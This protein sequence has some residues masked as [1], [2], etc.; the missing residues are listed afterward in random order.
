MVLNPHSISVVIPA[1]NEADNIGLLVS[2]IIEKTENIPLAEII[3][4]DD[5]STDNISA[6][7]EQLKPNASL[8]RL[9]RHSLRSGQSAAL[10]TGIQAARSE[11]IVTMDGDGQNDPVDIQT[12]YKEW[13]AHPKPPM[14]MIAGQRRKRMDTMLKKFTSQAG[15]GIRSFLLKDGVRDTG[16]SLKLFRREDYLRLPYFNHMHRFLPALFLR[17]GGCVILA[18]VSH[19]PRRKGVSKYGFWDRLWAGIFDIFGVLW[20]KARARKTIIVTEE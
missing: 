6:T 8:I 20:L 16:C 12:L 11:L 13:L 15:N 5:G 7:I 18:D 17:D 19:R 2:E 1:Y 3:I 4:V 9:L 14:A 10:Y